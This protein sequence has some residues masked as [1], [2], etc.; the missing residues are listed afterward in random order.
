MNI[1][2]NF[3]PKCGEPS[4]EGLCG[5]CRVKE[6]EWLICEPR[7]QCIHCPTCGSLKHGKTWTDE[8][9][10]LDELAYELA[11]N[12]VHLHEDVYDT[13]NE[14]ETY[15]PNPNRTVCTVSISARLYGIPIED[16]CKVLIIWSKEQCNRCSRYAG[17][18]YEGN[19]Q[20]RAT[21]RKP[22]PYENKRAAEIAYNTEDE[23]QEAG[24]RLSFLSQ[25]DETK[26]GLDIIIGSHHIG[27][28]ISRKIIKEFGGKITTH[29]KVVGEKDGKPLHRITYLVRLPRYRKGD[30]IEIKN[31]Y[32]EV[33]W[34]DKG[35]INIFDLKEGIM[36]A[37]HD[38]SQGRLIGNV[39]D[40]ETALVAYITSDMAGILDPVTYRNIE[41][42]AYDW[43]NLSEGAEIRML[44]DNESEQFILIG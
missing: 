32:Y 30:V 35:F 29:P 2:K 31:R 6:T 7:V 22:D 16:K 1:Q 40:T 25:V 11:A 24:E 42:A 23:L 5:K 33:R 17:G 13:K 43:L 36:K 3:C 10:N 27:E 8:E 20:V 14:I 39:C 28:L 9:R 12:A 26:D 34:V 37:F 15:S 21:G 44:R 38:D 19:I 4:E 41:C 18:Y